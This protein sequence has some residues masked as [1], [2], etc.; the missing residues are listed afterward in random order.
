MV[1]PNDFYV[2]NAFFTN[3]QTMALALKN[4]DFRLKLL[5]FD[6]GNIQINVSLSKGWNQD[7]Y[8]Q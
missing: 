3:N 1:L 8:L 6:N 5:I 4:L 2:S 7:V